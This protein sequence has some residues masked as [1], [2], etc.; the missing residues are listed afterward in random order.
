MPVLRVR[1][2]GSVEKVLVSGERNSS[3]GVSC[4]LV[5]T[6]GASEEYGTSFPTSPNP[7]QLFYRTDLDC[8]FYYDSS[9]SKWLGVDLEHIDGAYNGNLAAG[10]YL[11]LMAGVTMSNTKGA[12]VLYA[13]TIVGC[14]WTF[15]L[16]PSG[17]LEVMRSGVAVSTIDYSSSNMSA[18]WNLNDDFS[19]G[20]I[21]AVRNKAGSDQLDTPY[22]RVYW[23]RRAT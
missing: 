6:G 23:R 12:C 2:D 9:R 14:S 22:I 3:G 1:A 21:L 20:G 15:A 8:Q 10:A 13:S 5:V 7:G 17:Y 11:A 19:A 18:V 4:K 16:S